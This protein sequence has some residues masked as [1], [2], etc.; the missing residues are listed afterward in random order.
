[1]P[2]KPAE[3]GSYL[4]ADAYE[5]GGFSNLEETKIERFRVQLSKPVDNTTVEA[6]G[7]AATYYQ[8]CVNAS[9]LTDDNMDS[10]V[11]DFLYGL[12]TQLGMYASSDNPVEH[13]QKAG[14]IIFYLGGWPLVGIGESSQTYDIN[15]EGGF[16]TEIL[17]GS[18]AFLDL[19]VQAN[20]SSYILTVREA[21]YTCTLKLDCLMVHLVCVLPVTVK[22]M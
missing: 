17:Y 19:S 6:I 13:V 14:I 20:G 2:P 9:T 8:S 10:Q 12:L 21:E 1:M 5:T 7:K 15:D 18:D 3:S 4:H 22:L 16:L 11:R